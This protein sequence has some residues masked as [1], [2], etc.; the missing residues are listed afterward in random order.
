VKKNRASNPPPPPRGAR[1]SK[2]Y[3]RY[4]IHH[5]LYPNLDSP[6]AIRSSILT[7]LTYSNRDL[8][9]GANL[10]FRISGCLYGS[11]SQ[12]NRFV[13]GAEEGRIGKKA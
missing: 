7:L 11:Q 12:A 9:Q 3:S 5:L 8:L 2:I 4:P 10:R 6:Y 13:G 1:V